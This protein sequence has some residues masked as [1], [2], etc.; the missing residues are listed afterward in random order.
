MSG[1]DRTSSKPD[2][3]IVGVPKCGTTSIYSYLQ[4]H[5]QVFLPKWKEPHCFGSDLDFHGSRRLELEDY[6]ALFC[7]ARFDQKIG[8]ASV[9]YLYSS[10]AASEIRSF[11]P[12]AHILIALRNPVDLLHSF[13]SQPVYN[14]TE[15]IASFEDALA[16][17]ADRRNGLRL[18]RNIGL[19][20]CLFYR[21]LA[22]LG[23]QVERYV[24]LFRRDQMHFVLF[25]DLKSR[26]AETYAEICSFLGVDD[27]FMPSFSAQNPNK[28]SRSAFVLELL[29][30][31]HPAVRRVAR[32]FPRFLRSDLRGRLR[33]LNTRYQKR[34]AMDAELRQP[35]LAGLRG[36]LE[37]LQALIGRDLSGWMRD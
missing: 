37:K 20:Q 2:F 31:P 9:F 15:D 1:T 12:E 27:S 25:E 7:E 22:R 24:D 23:D 4:A 33:A 30:N 3:F 26:T 35:L 19:R 6:L 16:A 21:D 5:S 29:W 32:T 13:H 34:P 28:V 17:E 10:Q 11:N 18:P 14:G 36:D 8:D